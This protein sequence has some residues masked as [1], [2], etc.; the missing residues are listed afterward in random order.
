M[1]VI[2]YCFHMS[3]IQP[4]L[5]IPSQKS[6]LPMK[7]FC[8]TSHVTPRWGGE[9]ISH[10]GPNDSDVFLFLPSYSPPTPATC[11]HKNPT[12]LT[13]SAGFFFLFFF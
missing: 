3:A 5:P 7:S 11:K 6:S 12:K 4:F 13:V 1:G 10:R 8:V 9:D 2:D